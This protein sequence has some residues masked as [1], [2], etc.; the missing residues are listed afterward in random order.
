MDFTSPAFWTALGAIILADI[1]LSGDNA[2]VIAMA[3]RNLPDK[4]RKQCIFWGSAGAI[5][6]RVL[7][8]IVAV[9]LLKIPF[10]KIIGGV[11]L[12][13]IAVQL[14]SSDDDEENITPQG[15]MWAAIRTII[16]ADLAMSIDNVIA[17]AGAADTAPE[18]TRIPLLIF[19]FA[20]S[21]PLIMVG[22][23]MLLKIMDRYPMIIV[24]GAA[25]LGFLA[26]QM[27]ATDI[28]VVQWVK[29]TIPYGE[30]ILGTICA[31]GV[32][33]VGKRISKGSQSTAAT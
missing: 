28:A 27:L 18:A 1:L 23:T 26:G 12:L 19:G 8:T 32:V 7:L 3:A 29:A 13:W 4:Q 14:L 25:I 10:L 33:V 22:S 20:L 21:V 6:L 16:I 24:I 11:M 15:S 31:I 17:V 30:Y 5:T 9:Y 2:V